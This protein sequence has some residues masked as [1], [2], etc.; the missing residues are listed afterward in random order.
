L[1]IA[2]RIGVAFSECVQMESVKTARV[3]E[4]VTGNARRIVVGEVSLRQTF[5][6][7]RHR[8]F[9]LFFYGQ[10]VSLTGTWIQQTAM[11]WLVY[12]LTGS[13]LLLGA[14]AAAGSAPMMVFSMWGGSL[15]DRYPKRTILVATQT[16]QM[17][18]AFWLAALVWA[19]MATPWMIAGI[20]LLNGIAMGFDM[21]ARQAFTVEMT[22]REDLLNAISLNSSVV[23]GA[24]VLGPSLAGLLMG[25]VG[26]AMCFFLNGVSYIAVIAGLMTMRLPAHVPVATTTSVRAH[27]LGG[28]SYV[29][30]HPRVRT[31]LGL[32]GVV[33][34]FGWSYAVLMP[35]FARDVL[36][37]GAHGY[38]VLM[39]ASGIGA[40][41]GALAVA[42]AG[43]IFKPRKV[44]LGGVWL[45][46]AALLAFALDRNFYL[47]LLFLA[48]A[49]FG[50]ML[51]F[52]TS[53]TVLQTIVPD[54][55]RGRV[56]GIWAVVFGA[57]VPIGSLQAGALAHW[58]GSPVTIIIGALVCALA[59]TVTLLVV[60]RRDVS[61]EN[62]QI[63]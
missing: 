38:G 41:V 61:E 34:I 2:F 17:L 49:G 42:T 59:A 18:L 48:L 11:S 30:R 12:Q 13:K 57:M 32:F 4:D 24:R 33:G 5:R 10:L 63:Q 8:N 44:A 23:N 55:M 60:R 54:E 58:L 25:S 16:A 27:A 36:G 14:I 19:G 50:M 15:A 46:S 47:S 20:A 1:R 29:F 37:L 21:P 52:S 9:R 22:S 43:H 53:N 40:L 6:A 28:L 62:S 31:I 45:F 7:L 3:P 35:A 26:V 56:M 39:S 51:F